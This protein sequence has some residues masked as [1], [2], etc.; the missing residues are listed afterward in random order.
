IIPGRI[1]FD[2][3]WLTPYLKVIKFDGGYKKT[4]GYWETDNPI[5]RYV[6]PGQRSR[7]SQLNCKIL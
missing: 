1:A 7:S 5:S 4:D 6:C 2:K 3:L